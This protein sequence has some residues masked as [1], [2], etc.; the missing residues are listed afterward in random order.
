M[1]T[2]QTE[3]LLLVS[4]P[5]H[6]LSTRIECDDFEADVPLQAGSDGD[7]R[8]Q[9]LRVH[10]P[11]EWPGEA[12]V[13]FPGWKEALKTDPS[14]EMWGGT[15]I[16]RSGRV[17]VGQMTLRPLLGDPGVVELGYGVNPTCWGRGYATEAARALVQW[18]LEEPRIH[19][20]ASACLEDNIASIRVL[21]KVGFTRTGE[22]MDDEGRFILWEYLRGV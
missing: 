12:V 14:F 22:E 16:D 18:A 21:E 7:D 15:M 5:L 4:T 19:R 8:G 3:R 6:I 13:L 20:I 9:V 11:P 10:F 1:F 17:A 2:L